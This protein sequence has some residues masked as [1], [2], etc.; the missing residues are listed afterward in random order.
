MN[1][2]KPDWSALTDITP[3]NLLEVTIDTE[4]HADTESLIGWLE[5]HA[6]FTHNEA[7]EFILWVP[8]EDKVATAYGIG[9]PSFVER[10]VA[11]AREIQQGKDDQG[12]LLIALL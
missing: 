2:G 6:T 5:G 12:F 1:R 9:I 7:D 10:S 3:R 8:P 11:K 4:E